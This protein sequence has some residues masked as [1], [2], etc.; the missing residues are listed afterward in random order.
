MFFCLKSPASSYLIN[1]Y[2]YQWKALDDESSGADHFD[3]PLKASLLTWLNASTYRSL[4]VI[5]LRVQLK[6][7]AMKEIFIMRNECS[8]I[9]L[10]WTLFFTGSAYHDYCLVHYLFESM[11]SQKMLKWLDLDWESSRMLKIDYYSYLI[12]FVILHFPIAISNLQTGAYLYYR[13]GLRA[14]W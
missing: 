13:Q 2:C 5:L 4:I 14:F 6:Q 9:D 7:I 3:A 11:G 12:H 10:S 8:T 1:D